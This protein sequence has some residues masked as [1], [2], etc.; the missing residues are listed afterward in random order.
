MS[1]FGS[2]VAPHQVEDRVRVVLTTWMDTYLREA[3]R[4]D[5]DETLSLPSVQSWAL[6]PSADSRFP[7][8][9]LPGVSIAWEHAPLVQ[10]ATS[11]DAEVAM[12]LD[13]IVQSNGREAVRKR[14][15]IYAYCLAKIVVDKLIA[16]PLVIGVSTPELG[17]P[18]VT[19]P[20][21]RRWLAHG[22]VDFTLSVR[23][24]MTPM[25][26]PEQPSPTPGEWP[27]A[28]TVVVTTY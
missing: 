19:N 11:M 10:G 5:T 25:A 8:Q 15:G 13:V 9:G 6:V 18:E 14:A 4:V 26:A 2:W 7:G 24:V 12:G 22:T 16:D 27:T 17:L 1:V 21:T 28:E 23:D 3:E 20:E